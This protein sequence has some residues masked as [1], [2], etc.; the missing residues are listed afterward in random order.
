MS[1][2]KNKDTDY[3]F[4]TSMLRARESKMLSDDKLTRLL[5]TPGFDDAAKLI[6]DSG[7]TDM[8]GMTMLQV[9]E[10]LDEH[11]AAA[12][13]EL[14]HYSQAVGLL[15][16]FR[17]KYDYHNV[18]VLVKAMGANIDGTQLLSDAGRI[19]AKT[20]TEAFNTGERQFLPTAISAAISNAVGI[21]S[22]TFDPQLSDLEIDKHYYRELLDK[23]AALDVDF[24]TGYAR[25][26]IDSANLRT[27]VRMLRMKKDQA[28]LQK[29]LIDGGTLRPDLFLKLSPTGEE[30][31]EIYDA[32]VLA[33]AAHL[34][35]S[36]IGGGTL[37]AFE[38]E[39]DDALIRYLFKAKLIGFGTAPVLAYIA[40]LESELMSI[41]MILTAKRSGIMPEVI[42]ERLRTS[43]V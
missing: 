21:L 42:R 1:N 19:P 26:L 7:Y 32:G 8:S 31:K 38:R 41:R 14:A 35:Q 2:N 22:R 12:F 28:L 23:A 30:L 29:F 37:T 18:K 3:L 16:I 10:A 24:I 9:D 43:Y 20:L 36:A 11:R 13:R 33:N 34:G 17:L 6:A 39:C 27:A 25:L 4:L 5:E 40:A 15:D